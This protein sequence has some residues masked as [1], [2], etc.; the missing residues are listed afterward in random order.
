MLSRIAEEF[1]LPPDEAERI[2]RRDTRGLIEEVL[3]YRAYARAKD[4][5]D[6]VEGRVEQLPQSWV[7]DCVIENDFWWLRR[8]RQHADDGRPGRTD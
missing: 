5:Y 3:L 2:W 6:R 1:H 7:M 4:A 8:R